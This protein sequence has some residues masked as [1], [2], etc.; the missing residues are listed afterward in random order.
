MKVSILDAHDRLQHFH[1][2][3]DQI[4]LACQECIDKRPAE[5]GSYPFFIF[6]HQRQIDL[7]ERQDSFNYDLTN[8][9][10]D[11]SYKRRYARL[12]DVET[13]R[14]IWIPRLSKPKSQTNSMLFKSYP[15]IGNIEIIW[16]IPARELWQEF[17][18]DK[19]AENKTVIDSIDAFENHRQRL[20]A[21]DEDQL[22][23][24]IIDKIYQEIAYN[25][26]MSKIKLRI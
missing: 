5:F 13:A 26:R 14:L 22:P 11:L 21:P 12:E 9:F 25:A 19:L 3:S 24:A 7:D 18:K 2:Q 23:D 15:G 16:I 4:S 8:S 1:K 10:I 17:Q 6:A 20:D